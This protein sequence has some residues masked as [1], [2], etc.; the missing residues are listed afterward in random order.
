MTDTN[1]WICG[2][3]VLEIPV[4]S[5]HK[6]LFNPVGHGGA[7]VV[8]EPAYRIF[9]RFQRPITPGDALKGW[10]GRS[11]DVAEIFSRLSQEDPVP[12]VRREQSPDRV[13]ARDQCL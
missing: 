3:E 13:V 6:V 4:D 1:R 8:N 7:V 10:P 11:G 12:R 5:E 2:P 9:H